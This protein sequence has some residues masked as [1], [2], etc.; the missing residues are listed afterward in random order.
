MRRPRGRRAGRGARR[1]FETI[2][3]GSHAGLL[4]CGQEPK[5]EVSAQDPVRLTVSK[6]NHGSARKK[7]ASDRHELSVTASFCQR[8]AL[9]GDPEAEGVW[10]PAGA[11]LVG[12]PC[13][14]FRRS[15]HDHREHLEP[16]TVAVATGVRADEGRASA[17]SGGYSWPTCSKKRGTSSRAG[18]VRSASSALSSA[19]LRASGSGMSRA[20]SPV[21]FAHRCASGAVNASGMGSTRIGFR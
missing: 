18:Q 15:G 7:A 8:P 12:R 21:S 19:Q 3:Q 1:H 16:A 4:D 14:R 17:Q 10:L 11:G 5:G 13:H 20:G 6:T 2:E 9:L